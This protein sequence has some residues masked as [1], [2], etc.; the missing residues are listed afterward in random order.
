ME[1]RETNDSCLVA[2]ELTD[3]HVKNLKKK[4]KKKEVLEETKPKAVLGTME[5]G[6]R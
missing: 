5:K 1:D 2:N 6:V 3:D 4:K